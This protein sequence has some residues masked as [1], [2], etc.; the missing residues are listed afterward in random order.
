MNSASRENVKYR[1]LA[2]N[3]DSKTCPV[4]WP[5]AALPINIL[6]KVF[7]KSTSET[8]GFKSESPS[9]LKNL[10]SEDMDSL[11]FLFI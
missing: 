6:W 10:A 11:F 5:W 1:L 4:T 8:K 7:V 2:V 9:L 3:I